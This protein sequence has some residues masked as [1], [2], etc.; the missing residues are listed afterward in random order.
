[1]A[2]DEEGNIS[3][4]GQEDGDGERSSNE[5]GEDTD[6]FSDGY[7][8]GET[9]GKNVRRR[10]SD[11][12]NSR[13]KKAKIAKS[14]VDNSRKRRRSSTSN[15]IRSRKSRRTRLKVNYNEDIEDDTS[16]SENIVDSED[17]SNHIIGVSSRGRLRKAA[18]RYAD[19]VES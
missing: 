5:D 10:T 14:T 19:F 15:D 18:L 6:G 17:D 13:S 9:V 8:T 16:S 1:M 11:K 2:Q 4:Y 7:D 3:E 12:R